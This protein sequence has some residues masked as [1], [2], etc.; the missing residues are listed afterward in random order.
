MKILSTN[1][2]AATL[3]CTVTVFFHEID[4]YLKIFRSLKSQTMSMSFD[5]PQSA[6]EQLK[7]FIMLCRTKPEIIHKEEL[8]FFRDSLARSSQ[9][10][11]KAG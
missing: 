3:P 2:R 11:L 5:L 7:G 4:T 10:F 6:L 9:F 1:H 8:S